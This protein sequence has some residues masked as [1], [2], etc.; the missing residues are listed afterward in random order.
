VEDQETL[1]ACTIVCQLMDL[2]Q[3]Q[4]HDFLIDGIMATREVFGGIFFTID[5]F[6][7]LK[8]LLIFVV[9]NFIY[10]SWFLIQKKMAR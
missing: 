4:I 3:A 7:W 8:K 1:Q 9:S 5:E 2:I 6:L 10:D